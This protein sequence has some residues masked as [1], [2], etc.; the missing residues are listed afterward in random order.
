MITAVLGC[1]LQ[2][3][4]SSLDLGKA[5]FGLAVMKSC[6]IKMFLVEKS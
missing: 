2:S 3:V 5:F 6:S 4:C 1:S